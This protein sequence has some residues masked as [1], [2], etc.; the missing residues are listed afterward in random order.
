MKK[1]KLSE[2]KYKK[3][4]KKLSKIQLIRIVFFSLASVLFII[5]TIFSTIK[6]PIN[7]SI[8]KLNTTRHE[9]EKIYEKEFDRL[10]EIY[11]S[12]T[13]VSDYENQ[14][15]T[16]SFLELLYKYSYQERN[17]GTKTLIFK[18]YNNSKFSV[19][20]MYSIYFKNRESSI[21]EYTI[22]ANERILFSNNSETYILIVSDDFEINDYIIYATSVK[23]DNSIYNTW[24]I[25]SYENELERTKITSITL[26]IRNQI[27][28]RPTIENEETDP[29]P[30][31]LR[32]IN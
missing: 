11:D 1:G 9:R 12:S 29:I 24:H 20:S 21:T 17:D 8:Y 7:G 23:Y 3:N 14:V 18:V 30:D 4:K 28:E 22:K 31:Y 13:Q 19:T 10:F 26:M 2:I 6:M 27:G 15:Q 25:D 32:K 16:S 5:A